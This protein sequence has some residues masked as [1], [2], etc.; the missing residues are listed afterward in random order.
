M[1]TATTLL[2]LVPTDEI[3]NGMFNVEGF[4]KMGLL[5]ASLMFLVIISSALG[6]HGFIPNLKVPPPR[7]ALSIKIIYL[8]IF[9]TLATKS[10]LALFLA[11]MCGAIGSGVAATLSYYVYAFIFE[12]SS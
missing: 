3:S 9:E 11:A 12:F 7:R 1:A 4:N 8:E 2:L 5:G 6:T 10:F